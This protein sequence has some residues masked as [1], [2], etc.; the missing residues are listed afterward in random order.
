MIIDQ[1]DQDD[2]DDW[3]KV[4][5]CENYHYDDQWFQLEEDLGKYT[6]DMV[7]KLFIAG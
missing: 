6:D 4:D 3:D 2:Q 5:R 7:L 1:V